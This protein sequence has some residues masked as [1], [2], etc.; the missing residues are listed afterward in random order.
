VTLAATAGY[1]ALFTTIEGFA[2]AGADRFMVKRFEVR[3]DLSWF[4]Q[5]LPG[6][7]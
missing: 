1:E 3:D 7:S 2:A 4:R 5:L 6:T